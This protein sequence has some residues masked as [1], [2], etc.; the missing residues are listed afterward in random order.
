VTGSERACWRIIINARHASFGCWVGLS[1]LLGR[2]AAE[3][4]PAGQLMHTTAVHR[5][6]SLRRLEDLRSSSSPF[7][8]LIL[9]YRPPPRRIATPVAFVTPCWEYFLR[10][11]VTHAVG[12]LVFDSAADF[13]QLNRQSAIQ[14]LFVNVPV[15]AKSYRQKIFIESFFRKAESDG[16]IE[17][18][19]KRNCCSK[20]H[21]R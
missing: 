5:S 16:H 1:A 12:G 15:K 4:E 14:S 11:G 19:G 3:A 9:T 17:F 8:Y 20:Y 7:A 10:G 2:S 6:N 13:R 21:V 18:Q